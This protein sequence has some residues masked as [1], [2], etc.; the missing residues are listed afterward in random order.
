MLLFSMN[1]SQRKRLI[2]S[3]SS[4]LFLII[5]SCSD[6][7][8]GP[9]DIEY[10]TDVNGTKILY[11]I[12][13]LSP[14]GF[15]E[16]IDE[17]TK[18]DFV[19]DYF[20]DEEIE[21]NKI[22]LG[23]WDSFLGIFKDD[24]ENSKERFRIGFVNGLKHGPFEFRH[25]NGKIRLKGNYKNGKRHGKFSS[26]GKIGE[27][28]Y[29]KNFLNG[30][31]DGNFSLYYVASEGDIYRYK[32]T[33]KQNKDLVVKNHIRLRAKFQ[34]GN[35]IGS[36]K[37]YY[38]PGDRKNLNES[39]LLKE[40]GFFNED[41]LLAN[42]QTKFYPKTEKLFV[43][44]PDQEKIEFPATN[45]GLSRAIDSARSNI[46][47]LPPHRNPEKKPALV[48]TADEKD[49]LIS[50]IWSSHINSIILRKAISEEIIET[51]PA[52]YEAFVNDAHR[53]GIEMIQNNDAN[54]SSNRLDLQIVGVAE[55]GE[56][57][58]VLWDSRESK[59]VIPM[60]ER[61]FAQRTKTHR[62]WK[63]GSATSASWFLSD[64]S[65]LPLRSK[66]NTQ[67]SLEFD[68]EL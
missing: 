39:D 43:V 27:L 5:C 31:L 42:E 26:Y 8:V 22:E 28:N 65:Q 18:P 50:P 58:D 61:I 48:Y 14:Y 12:T 47:E 41:G 16:K 1:H 34:K 15:R 11:E 45:N 68:P 33:L 60:N 4:F 37:S 67:N 53:K 66:T 32:E 40:E 38:H 23:L 49:N 59:E 51:Y 25:P 13:Q 17:G 54:K 56:T 55:S 3:L 7:T 57:V 63:E 24:D 30:E 10:R 29:E 64:G 9:A 35:P 20:T 62:T 21:N 52:N 46:L 36:Y 44:L 19:V 6:K 2:N